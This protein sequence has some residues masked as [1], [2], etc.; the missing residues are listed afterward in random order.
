MANPKSSGVKP[1][2]RRRWVGCQ[3]G[4]AACCAPYEDEF[5]ARRQD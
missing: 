4:G 2:L 3:V 1:L 5:V